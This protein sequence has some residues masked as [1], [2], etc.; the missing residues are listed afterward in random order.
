MSELLNY[1]PFAAT[2]F[3]VLDKHAHQLDVVVLSATFDAL[4]NRPVRLSDEQ[5][6]VFDANQHDGQ[7]GL[8]SVRYEGEIAP[9]K[10]LVDVLVNGSAVAPPGPLSTGLS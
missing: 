6:P 8:S 5:P 2:T 4:P 3:G 9:T 7:P 1:T 10:P